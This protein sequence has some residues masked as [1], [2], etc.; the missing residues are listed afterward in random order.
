MELQASSLVAFNCSDRT[1]PGHRPC[2][3]ACCS[4]TVNIQYVYI[5]KN[6]IQYVFK[7]IKEGRL[8]SVVRRDQFILRVS[9]S[10]RESWPSFSSICM[11]SKTHCYNWIQYLDCLVYLVTVLHFKMKSMLVLLSNLLS[12]NWYKRQQI[13]LPC[14]GINCFRNG[15]TDRWVGG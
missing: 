14:G 12:L 6:E 9:V 1:G 4:V 3:K 7:W 11:K 15:W 13:Q 5:F 8:W 2:P 10:H